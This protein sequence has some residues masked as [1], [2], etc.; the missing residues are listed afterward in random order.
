MLLNGD[1]IFTPQL[2]RLVVS[3][4][5]RYVHSLSAAFQYMIWKRR[6]PIDD[7]LY[8]SYVHRLPAPLSRARESTRTI[9]CARQTTTTSLQ[10]IAPGVPTELQ[11]HAIDFIHRDEAHTHT[12]TLSASECYSV[13]C[14]LSQKVHRK[15]NTNKCFYLSCRR[16]H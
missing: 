5:P 9:A 7:R 14:V 3:T 13:F 16:L 12:H 4:A 10:I 11:C 8:N 6:D 15:L 2:I 1:C